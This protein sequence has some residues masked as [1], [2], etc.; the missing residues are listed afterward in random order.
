LTA[1]AD[2]LARLRAA[3][4]GA[5]A[6]DRE[7]ALA[8]GWRF[9]DSEELWA[10]PGDTDAPDRFAECH[11]HRGPWQDGE[12]RWPDDPPPFTASTEAALYGLDMAVSYIDIA[13]TPGDDVW[14]V[15]IIGDGWGDRGIAATLPLAILVARIMLLEGTGE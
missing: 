9:D 5:P 2:L 12:W 4:A 1:R 10:E 3:P 7:V 15:G 11:D 8:L 13:W 14:H 6:L